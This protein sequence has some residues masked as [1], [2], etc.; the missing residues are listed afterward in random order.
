M[1]W[2][3]LSLALGLVAFGWLT[4]P[5]KLEPSFSEQSVDGDLDALL[6]EREAAVGAAIIDGAEKR[7][8][9][10]AAPGER[11]EY[12]VIYLHGFSATRQEIAPV[13]EQVADA[14]GA[15]LFETRLAGHGLEQDALVGMSA[16]QWL[17]DGSEA[18]AV[19]TALGERL[20]LMGTSTGATLALSLAQHPQFSAVEAL[21]L[22]SPNFGP[23]AGG[24]GLATGPMGPQLI[25]LV[26]GEYR[27]W[28][29]AN[30]RQ[31]RYWHTRYPTTA[32]I[33]MMRLVDL[34]VAET[35]AARVPKAMLI[36]SPND[37]VVSVQRL[38]RGFERL[39]A[40]E[41]AVHQILS[42]GGPSNHVL[43]GDILAPENNLTTSAMITSFL[44]SE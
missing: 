3:S 43:A 35:A 29:P 7:I 8:R 39:P 9:W 24:S 12:V 44:H 41:K 38:L 25:R 34:A 40:G 19:G 33:E 22:L 17:E 28:E 13:P 18:L 6:A 20:I 26:A 36:Y 1:V 5:A 10:A 11:T 37:Q 15:N 32:L 21:I 30:E 14:L 42:G 27:E 4:K 2:I 16:E 23:S 31:G